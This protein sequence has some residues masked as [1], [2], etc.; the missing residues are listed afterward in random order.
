MPFDGKNCKVMKK[1]RKNSYLVESGLASFADRVQSELVQASR[2]RNGGIIVHAISAIYGPIITAEIVHGTVTT[3]V[4]Q[5]I[6]AGFLVQSPIDTL[7]KAKFF[8]LCLFLAIFRIYLEEF[9][10]VF[11]VGV[12]LHTIGLGTSAWSILGI[13]QP[14]KS[15]KNK[16]P[17]G[18]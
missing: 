16:A 5:T 14:Q 7:W 3:I 11:G 1:S 17:H 2:R 13:C 12:G 18:Y 8:F 6:F 10:T 9:I 15:Q 4:H